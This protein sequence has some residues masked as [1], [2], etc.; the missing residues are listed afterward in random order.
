[1]ESPH[2]PPEFFPL[3]SPQKLQPQCGISTQEGH[4]TALG[5]VQCGIS[6]QE[7]HS[8]A[9]GRVQCGISAQEGHSMALGRVSFSPMSPEPRPG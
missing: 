9:L 2:L 3:K 7:G 8:T 6:A 1:M 4:S 5:R